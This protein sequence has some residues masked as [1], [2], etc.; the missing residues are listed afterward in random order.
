MCGVQ[1][2]VRMQIHHLRGDSARARAWADSA[3]GAIQSQLQSVPNDAQLHAFLGLASAVL[4]RRG[5]AIEEGER[6][7]D[8]VPSRR[9]GWNGPYLEHLLVRIYMLAGEPDKANR[10][11]WVDEFSGRLDQG[12]GGAYVNFV[13][14]EGPERVRAAYPGGTWE[15]LRRIKQQYDP[16]NVF[17][18]N[19]NI[20]P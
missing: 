11:A 4:G 16:T 18:R 8:L 7:V 20:A 15:R 1:A 12:V 19:E 3:R 17:R 6:A 14:N 2:M 13:N 9:D 5:E 10:Q